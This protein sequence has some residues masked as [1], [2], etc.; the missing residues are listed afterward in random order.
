M[1]RLSSEIQSILHEARE[2]GS[3]RLDEAT[4]TTGLEIVADAFRKLKVPAQSWPKVGMNRF[5]FWQGTAF[6]PN[7]VD[8]FLSSDGK[9]FQWVLGFGKKEGPSGSLPVAK[10]IKALQRIR[11]YI[12]NPDD[13]IKRLPLGEESRVG[14]RS[15]QAIRSTCGAASRDRTAR[16]R[17]KGSREGAGGPRRGVDDLGQR[18]VVSL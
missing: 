5:G 3:E 15:C 16:R 18:H 2:G 17:A 14:R 8:V 12:K 13:R 6:F 10:R 11:K 1:R 7:D 9:E 4:D